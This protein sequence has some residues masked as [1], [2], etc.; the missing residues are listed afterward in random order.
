[1]LWSGVVFVTGIFI[2][3]TLILGYW[4]SVLGADAMPAIALG[5][6]LYSVLRHRAV[7]VSVTL[8]RTLVYA[9]SGWLRLSSD[10]TGE[11]DQRSRGRRAT[12]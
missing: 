8:S 10:G 4:V 2:S 3:N 7:D 12:P 1:M 5:G 11:P 6:F 9:M